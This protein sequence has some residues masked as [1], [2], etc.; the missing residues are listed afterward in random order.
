MLYPFWHKDSAA[1]KGVGQRFDMNIARLSKN[2]LGGV[3]V[4]SIR[5]QDSRSHK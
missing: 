1:R 3:G 4:F 5:T 2:G